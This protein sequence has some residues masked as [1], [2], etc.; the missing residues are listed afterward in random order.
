[1]E[2][3]TIIVIAKEAFNRKN[4]TL[5]KQTKLFMLDFRVLDL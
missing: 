4:I 5:D 2:I 1:M 3:K